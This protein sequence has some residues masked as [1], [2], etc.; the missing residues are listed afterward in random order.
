MPCTAIA[1]K[2]PSFREFYQ[3]RSPD[4]LDKCRRFEAAYRQHVERAGG[5]DLHRVT[6]TSGLDHRIRAHSP[7]GGERELICF[8]S[9]SY[10]HLH[11][12]HRVVSAVRR[13]L[14]HVGYGTPSA[15]ALCG[16]N[17]YLREL[18]D[19]ISAFHGRQHTVVFPSGYS[20]NLGTITAL[21]RSRDLVVRDLFSHASIHDGC[22]ASDSRFV[23]TYPHQDNEA[24]ERVLAEASAL[25]GCHG[26]LIVSD[27]V[28]SMHGDVARLPDLVRAARRHGATLMLDEAHATGVIGPNGRGSEELFGLEGQVDIL[29]GTFSKAPGTIGGYVTGSRELVNYLRFYAH[30]CMFTAALPAA[31]CA[32]VTEAFRVMQDEP[33]HRERLWENVRALA[34]GLAEIGLSAPRSPESAI[35]P[36]FMGTDALLWRFGAELFACGIKA[37]IVAFPAVPQGEAM[38]RLT[39]NARHTCEDIEHTLTVLERLGRVFGILH[40]DPHEIRAIGARLA[41]TDAVASTDA[42][43]DT[44]TSL[45][46]GAA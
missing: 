23:R 28:F 41:P 14:N 44:C 20:A 36:V 37:G 27:G 38:I 16:T 42:D 15:Q 35:V 29:M 6:L 30:S 3:S 9:N 32:G 18:E 31:L 24:L 34:T 10:L 5:Q 45:E 40:K 39:V 26:K 19:T 7:S 1:D 4:L 17:R 8:D 12:H 25:P 13:V 11:R 22:R 21:V 2:T 33:E 43:V 46:R